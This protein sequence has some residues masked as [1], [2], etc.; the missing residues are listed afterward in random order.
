MSE[1]QP[2][3]DSMTEDEFAEYMTE[4]PVYFDKKLMYSIENGC[5]EH[6]HGVNRRI[7]LAI[8]TMDS[9]KVFQ[10]CE[11]APDVWIDAFKC[12]A[13][14]LGHYKRMVKILD[15]AH[16]RLMMGLCGVDFNA[17]DAPFSKKEFCGAI[18]EAK[19][20]DEK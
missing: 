5:Q 9:E 13:S 17:P 8:L 2:D 16:H 7:L 1:A 18:D 4:W 11:E 6:A 15:V 12:S 14:T 10:A 20:E 3:L 19:G